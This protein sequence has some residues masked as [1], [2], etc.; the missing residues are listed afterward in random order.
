MASCKS[1]LGK[2]GKAEFGTEPMTCLKDES[3]RQQRPG[4]MDEIV[5]LNN[6]HNADGILAKGSRYIS[7]VSTGADRNKLL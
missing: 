7:T 5:S 3:E 2:L 4:I 6:G 1:M